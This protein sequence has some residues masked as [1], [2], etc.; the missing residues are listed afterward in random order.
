MQ[1][2]NFVAGIEADVNYLGN[3]KGNGSFPPPADLGPASTTAPTSS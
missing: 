2:G 1:F 3:R